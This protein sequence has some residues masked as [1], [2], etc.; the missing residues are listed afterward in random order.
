[1]VGTTRGYMQLID[2]KVPGKCIKTFKTFT[3]SVT[4]IT[5]DP[6]EPLV[7]STSLDRFLR[8]HNLETKELLHKVT[9]V[10]IFG[11][12]LFAE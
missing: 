5:C 10:S 12:N 8:I 6:V 11:S 3:G 1:M 2:L 7:I 9:I 4:S